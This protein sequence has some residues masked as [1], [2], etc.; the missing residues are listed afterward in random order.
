AGRPIA[1]STSTTLDTY[2]SE[3]KIDRRTHRGLW[4]NV[5]GA[6]LGQ[7]PQAAPSGYPDSRLDAF[8][9]VKPPGE[10][11]GSS[12]EIPNDEG[13]HLDPMCDP[14]YTAPNAGGNK[15]GAM[16]GAPLA[17]HWFHEQFAMLVRNAHPA[18]GDDG[19][20]GGDTTAPTAP[21]GLRSTAQTAGSVS[22][23]WTASTDDTGVTG[24]DVYRDGTRVTS[25]PVTTT[26][27]TDTGLTAATAYAY[28]V[29]ARDAAGNVSA[30]SAALT[31]TTGTGDGGG[32]DPVGGVKVLYKNNDASVAD[33]AIRPGLRIV[34]T[35][36]GPLDLSGVTARYY[37]TRDG[38]SSTVGAWCDYAAVGCSNVSLR[39][40]PLST[41]VPGADAYLEVSFRSGTV[42]AGGNTGDIQ[43]RMAKSDWS[44]FDESDDHSRATV[45]SYTDAPKIPVYLGTELAW[46]TPPS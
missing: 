18:V 25:A 35:G 6:G 9:W 42:A 11:D 38:G 45:T 21:T 40:V 20:S 17:G 14:T 16:E 2:V 13:K 30:P 31:V 5:N 39:V 19:G 41:P 43:L 23:A 8:L 26:S 46:G 3:S 44:A 1:E 24:Y 34:N 36:T 10:S 22:L 7:P 33:N 29:R 37:F 32:P 4:C 12:T 15:T 27:F 28:T